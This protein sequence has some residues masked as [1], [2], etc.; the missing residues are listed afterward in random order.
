MQFLLNELELH[1]GPCPASSAELGNLFIEIGILPKEPEKEKRTPEGIAETIEYRL[2]EL[3]HVI[4]YY[5]SYYWNWSRD[6]ARFRKFLLK[7]RE[8]ERIREHNESIIDI[9]NNI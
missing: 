2:S 7:V 5:L 8:K 9:I 6:D 1:L 4:R 3:G